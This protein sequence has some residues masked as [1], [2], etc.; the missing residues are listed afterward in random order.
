M[1]WL[2]PRAK[3]QWIF[4]LAL[5]FSGFGLSWLWPGLGFI[6]ANKAK[7][8]SLPKAMAPSQA[9]PNTGQSQSQYITK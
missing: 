2:W 4:G 1:F 3:K 5:A 8:F 6:K 9:K 7:L